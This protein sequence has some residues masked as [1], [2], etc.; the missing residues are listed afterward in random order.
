MFISSLG[1]PRLKCALVVFIVFILFHA[2]K[3][4]LFP[5]QF[6]K[7]TNISFGL[8][9]LDISNQELAKETDRTL[10]PGSTS[11]LAVHG[12]ESQ[13]GISPDGCNV[14]ENGG[15]LHS[16]FRFGVSDEMTSWFGPNLTF[17]KD[18][19]FVI[20]PC[21]LCPPDSHLDYIIV[22]NS[23]VQHF[24][25]RLAIRKTFGRRDIFTHMHQ[26][27]VFLLGT[28]LEKEIS[29]RIITES[30]QYNDIVQGQFLDTYQNLTLKGI[31]G[32][33]WLA[34]FCPRADVIIKIDDDVILNIFMVVSYVVPVFR[35]QYHQLLCE[36]WPAGSKPIIRDDTNKWKVSEDQF[37][38]L[39]YYPFVHCNGYFVAITGKLIRPLLEASKVNHFFWIDD[40]YLY[41]MLARTVGDVQFRKLYRFLTYD[42]SYAKE[43]IIKRGLQ[44]TTMVLNDNNLD[45]ADS[46]HFYD[47]W[48]Q[49]TG[50]ITDSD[51]IQYHLNEYL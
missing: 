1:N 9:E 30:Q 14:S 26:R 28:T 20:N 34:K 16:W 7:S 45:R 35:H 3:L 46:K 42:F 23:A 21:E 36:S 29:R 13:T 15:T 19:E 12:Q 31:A 27:V 48:S 50:Q 22:V 38:G 33:R 24:D 51:R 32:L 43:C 6:I 5:N 18:T 49:L 25:R 11:R 37:R 44:C 41:G 39:D 10:T 8:P 40:I 2:N 17:L 4:L 47:L